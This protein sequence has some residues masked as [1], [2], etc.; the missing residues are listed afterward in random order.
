MQLSRRHRAVVISVLLWIAALGLLIW[1]F[2]S[3]SL[4]D[5][6]N[7]LSRLGIVP[8]LILVL[9]NVLIAYSFGIRWW[10]IL[11][12]QGFRIGYPLLA[13]YRLVAYSISYFTPGPHLGGEPLQAFLVNR[14]HG[15]PGYVAIASVTVDKL[16]E[17]LVNF[18]FLFAGVL[19]AVY[20]QFIPAFPAP[21]AIGAGLI[22]LC[23]P[24]MIMIM[25]S[26]G[27]RPLSALLDRLVPIDKRSKSRAYTLV[28]A[29]ENDAVALFQ[30]SPRVLFNAFLISVG[31]WI[32]LVGEY[33]LTLHFLGLDLTL[34]QLA[35]A[36]TAA[37]LAIMLPLPGGLGTLEASQ[38]FVMNLL[39]VDP[40]L[41]LSASLLIHTRDILFALLGLL[42]G[43]IAVGGWHTLWSNQTNS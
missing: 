39:G 22:L 29:S 30:E 36:V 2:R 3:V 24:V 4:D 38:V 5:L 33:W 41:G 1:A 6:L 11:R 20:T 28:G 40:A 16:L 10:L 13:S 27:I 35:V 18:G 37:R 42:W 19:I 21:L 32:A 34:G 15:V 25:L 9:V 14:R 12:A 7:I 26:R 23:L 43:N 17:I 8:L 31:V